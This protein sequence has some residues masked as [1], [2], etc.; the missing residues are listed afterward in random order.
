MG[1]TW[2]SLHDA[3][4]AGIFGEEGGGGTTPPGVGVQ[5]GGEGLRQ[6]I[7]GVAAPILK[8]NTGYY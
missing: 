3:F 5:G 7:E 4:A 8:A 6:E 1:S 2:G